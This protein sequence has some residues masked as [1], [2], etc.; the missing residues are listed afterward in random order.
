MEVADDF[1][2]GS[3]RRQ[4]MIAPL[5]EADVDIFAIFPV[6]YYQFYNG[7]NGGPAGLLDFATKSRTVAIRLSRQS[8][9]ARWTARSNS[10]SIFASSRVVIRAEGCRAA[11]VAGR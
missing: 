6:S 8:R 7:Q 11:G 10:I 9:L 2:T 5:K 1:L 3:Y 4:T